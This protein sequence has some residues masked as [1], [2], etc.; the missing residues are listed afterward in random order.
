MP[1]EIAQPTD[2]ISES[3]RLWTCLRSGGT[4]EAKIRDG[5]LT[6]ADLPMLQGMRSSTMSANR[7]A[8][9][10]EIVGRLEALF[11]HYPPRTMTGGQ[12]QVW[13]DWI[14]DVGHLPSDVLADACRKWRRANNRFAPSPG[15]LLAL[16]DNGYKYDEKIIDLAIKALEKKSP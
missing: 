8:N 2:T 14:E 7:P 12:A 15:Q 16:V 6:A 11:Q 10:G 9:E 5:L 3:K 4:F 1:N 13:R